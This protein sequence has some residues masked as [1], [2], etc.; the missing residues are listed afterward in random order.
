MARGEEGGTL[1][2][3]RVS[4]SPRHG[5]GGGALSWCCTYQT[6]RDRHGQ[7]EDMM[8]QEGGPK[9][10]VGKGKAQGWRDENA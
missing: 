3:L 5:G 7:E 2:E 8:Y 4:N 1:T 9:G 6:N 10:S